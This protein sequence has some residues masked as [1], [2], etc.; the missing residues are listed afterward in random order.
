[1]TV[2]NVSDS[3]VVTIKNVDYRVYITG[4]D[5]KTAVFILRNPDL[6]DKGVL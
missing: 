1:M 6:S 5:K 2:Q 4:A 3:F